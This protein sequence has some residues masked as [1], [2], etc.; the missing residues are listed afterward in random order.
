MEYE[1]VRVRGNAAGINGYF[2]YTEFT[3][4]TQAMTQSG[5]ASTTLVEKNR[6]WMLCSLHFPE[7]F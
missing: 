6:K 3:K 2:N 1:S 7:F 4:D 5:R